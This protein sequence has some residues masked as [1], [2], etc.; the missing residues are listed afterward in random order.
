MRFEVLSAECFYPEVAPHGGVQRKL[1]QQVW[2]TV[3]QIKQAQ[4]LGACSCIPSSNEF[5]VFAVTPYQDEIH[6]SS[7][8]VNSSFCLTSSGP[9]QKYFQQFW[10]AFLRVP[11]FDSTHSACISCEKF[12]GLWPFLAFSSETYLNKPFDLNSAYLSSEAK[13]LDRSIETP[14][15]F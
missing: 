14:I 15:D 7:G 13:N 4:R 11:C 10:T 5:I 8:R 12:T 1:E 9:K 3:L 6:P 2:H